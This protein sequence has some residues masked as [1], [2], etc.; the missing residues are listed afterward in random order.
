MKINSSQRGSMQVVI[1]FIIALFILAYYNVDVRG[2]VETTPVLKQ[3]FA[4]L[5][6]AWDGYLVPLWHFLVANV[7]ALFN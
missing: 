5:V 6:G 4:I 3:I 1:V 2:F 7:K